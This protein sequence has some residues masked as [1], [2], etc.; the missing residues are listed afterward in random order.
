MFLV[1]QNAPTIDPSV[2]A[3]AGPLYRLDVTTGRLRARFGSPDSLSPVGSE[4]ALAGG[5][6]AWPVWNFV[7]QA[8]H[9]LIRSSLASDFA[10]ASNSSSAPVMFVSATH[11]ACLTVQS[12]SSS[13]SSRTPTA[14]FPPHQPSDITASRLTAAASSPAARAN[15]SEAENARRY[16]NASAAA[17]RS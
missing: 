1:C 15:A 9:A 3:E 7:H 17:E 10:S 8:F 13:R 5:L 4:V 14:F 16:P 2:S 11:A 12:V 6:A